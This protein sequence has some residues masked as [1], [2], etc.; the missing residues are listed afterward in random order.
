MALAADGWDS[1]VV[2]QCE[3]KDIN[4]VASRVSAFLNA[5]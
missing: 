5:S 4:R 1:L 2:W 3:L